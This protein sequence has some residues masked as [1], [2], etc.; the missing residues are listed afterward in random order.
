MP[1]FCLD[2]EGTTYVLQAGPEFKLLGQNKIDEMF[3]STPAIAGGDLILRG[4]DHLF[5]VRE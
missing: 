1:V 2:E 4:V 5:C 3:W